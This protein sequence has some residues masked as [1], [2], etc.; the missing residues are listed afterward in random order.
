MTPI[1][2]SPILNNPCNYTMYTPLTTNTWIWLAQYP[3]P[4]GA[5]HP[6]EM[7]DLGFP[8]LWVIA[9]C[10]IWENIVEAIAKHDTIHDI[11]QIKQ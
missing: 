3:G 6:N 10:K 1:K 5:V 7:E 11:V 2:Q 9:I 8:F 4:G